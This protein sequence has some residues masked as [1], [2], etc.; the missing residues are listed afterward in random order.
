MSRAL[1]YPWIYVTQLL[2]WLVLMGSFFFLISFFMATP[3]AE[4]DLGGKSL[5]SHWEAAYKDHGAS[6][7]GGHNRPQYFRACGIR[8]DLARIQVLGRPGHP[9]LTKRWSGRV[10]D[11][12]PTSNHGPPA[13]QLDR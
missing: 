4:L 2:G 3:I 13:A 6:S 7:A 9:G 8:V 1:V 5:P 12:A 10:R 11:Q